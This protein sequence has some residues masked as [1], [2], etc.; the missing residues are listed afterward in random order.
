VKSEQVTEEDIFKSLFDAFSKYSK[1]IEE[2]FA[3]FFAIFTNFLDQEYYKIFENEM[4]PLK[5]AL[6]LEEIDSIQNSE[7]N[8]KNLLLSNSARANREKDSMFHKC[9]HFANTKLEVFLKLFT[10]CKSVSNFHK[11]PNFYD[12]LQ[13]FLRKGSI[14]I[15]KH[16]LECL[17]KF[18]K[19]EVN[20]HADNIRKFIKV[21]ICK[22]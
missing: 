21:L 2:N 13:V 14:N 22:L 4:L 8:L 17:L 12:L 15:Q 16:A 3:D 9:R 7:E 5:I 11:V 6:S 18:E 10:T 19:S 1:P 20:Q